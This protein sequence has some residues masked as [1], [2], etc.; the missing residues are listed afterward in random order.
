LGLDALKLHLG[1]EETSYDYQ[2]R[3]VERVADI[4]EAKYHLVEIFFEENEDRI[5]Q[6]LAGAQ[7]KAISD[8][9][10]GKTRKVVLRRP[11]AIKIERMFRSAINRQEFDGIA[12][13]T[14][15]AVSQSGRSRAFRSRKGSSRASFVDSGTYR[16]SFRVWME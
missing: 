8:I 14:P 6:V 5:M 2:P 3:S 10:A 9:A 16:D 13:G 7:D 15:T 4:L 12:P 1:F 11:D